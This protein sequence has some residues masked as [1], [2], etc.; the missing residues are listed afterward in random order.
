VGGRRDPAAQASLQAAIVSSCNLSRRGEPPSPV[1]RQ[2]GRRRRE[3]PLHEKPPE[4]ELE[5]EEDGS[6]SSP[7][8][9][10]SAS[11]SCRAM[12]MLAFGA[13]AVCGGP[14]LTDR[15]LAPGPERSHAPAPESLHGATG[16][17]SRVQGRCQTT[18]RRRRRAA[19]RDDRGR[20][21][22]RDRRP[23]EADG[24]RTAMATATAM[25]HRTSSTS[26]RAQSRPRAA[27][28]ETMSPSASNGCSVW[29]R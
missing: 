13:A 29:P 28:L 22:R 25:R 5:P 11:R 23:S 8:W 18:S 19:A 4:L 1:R 9:A 12:R 16:P 2:L 15:P 7:S 26:Q 17:A 14:R 3:K 27:A 21:A 6:S 20:R 10:A 24:I